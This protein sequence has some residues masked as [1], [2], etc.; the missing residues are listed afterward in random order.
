MSSYQHKELI[1]AIT[2]L[3]EVPADSKLF[4]EWVKAEG[5]LGFLRRNAGADE[6]VIYASSKYTFIHAVAV[7]NDQLT[8][9]DQQDLLRWNFVDPF[10]S[11]ASYAANVIGGERDDVWIERGL[12]GT[13][14]K[15]LED[16]VQLIFGRTFEGWTRPGY[17][18]YELHQEYA[19]LQEIHWRP[20]AWAY[21]R[22]N[23]HGDLDHVVSMTNREDKASNMDLV[24]FKWEPLEEYLAVSNTSLVRM[25]EFDFTLCRQPG[26]V[27]GCS[28][29]P[30]REII[31]SP[32]LFYRQ[33]IMPDRAVYTRGVQ[34]I[35]PRRSP[36]TIFTSIKD[37]WFGE[38]NKQYVEFIAR[39]WRNQRVTKISTD[40]K[41]TTNYF[42]AEGNE[43]PFETSPVFFRP[44]VLRKYQTDHDKYTVGG[45]YVSCRAAWYLRGIGV[46]EA[47][48]IHT[49]IRYL[50]DLPYE[51]Q[52]Y[53]RAFNEPPETGISESAVIRDFLGQPLPANF[54]VQPLE[55]VLSI[56]GRWHNNKV[57]WW[58]LRNDK[59]FGYV[60]VPLTTSRD[61]WTKAFQNLANL[62]VEGFET[63]AIRGRL[64]TARVLYENEDKTL[65]LLE[66]FLTANAGEIQKLEC[67]R[68]VHHLR[69]IFAHANGSKAEQLAH[70]AL[71]KHE[72][73][74]N[75]FQHVCAQVADELDAIEKGMS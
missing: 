73:F 54:C 40:P 39:D 3:D 51:E 5:H 14:T 49:Y 50:R 13:D 15:T 48:Q 74:A 41:A 65:A 47:G 75:H 2:R 53:W 25:F 62:V 24:S 6:L 17:T 64:D 56:V 58:T 7:A 66:K 57:A 42:E 28:A 21:C 26:G 34:I 37:G 68:T 11:I 71:M 38:K 19:H 32:D 16:A 63:K 29:A 46:N 69:S 55:Q 4:S 27:S 33:K 70:D 10:R 67:L 52:S 12:S 60:N 36:Q 44:E 8:P 9:V 20:E 61:E 59:L 30:E 35:R 72:T 1:K 43:L 31:E 22:F 18:Y 45:G 23:K